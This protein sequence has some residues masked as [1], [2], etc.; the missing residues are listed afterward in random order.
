MSVNS[1]LDL[2]TYKHHCTPGDNEYREIDERDVMIPCRRC[3]STSNVYHSDTQVMYLCDECWGL[4]YQ[5][6]E[7]P[8]NR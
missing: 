4:Y 6:S 5:E 3:G 1:L 2:P 7:H 8:D